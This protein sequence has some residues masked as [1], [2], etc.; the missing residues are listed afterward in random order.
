MEVSDQL[1]APAILNTALGTYY[2]GDWIG[3][4]ARLDITEKK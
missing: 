4:R 1:H 2:T 3:H